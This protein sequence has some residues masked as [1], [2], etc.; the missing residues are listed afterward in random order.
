MKHSIAKTQN[1]AGTFDL[2]CRDCDF[3][4]TGLIVS[5]ANHMAADHRF[6]TAKK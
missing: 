2:A 4:M 6:T 5:Q 1:A 3:R